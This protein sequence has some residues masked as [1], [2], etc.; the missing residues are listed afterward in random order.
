M[1]QDKEIWID[2]GYQGLHSEAHFLRLKTLG[3]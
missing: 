1:N 2:N 3:S